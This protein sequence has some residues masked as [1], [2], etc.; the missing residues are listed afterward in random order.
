MCMGKGQ[1]HHHGGHSHGSLDEI[2][3]EVMP[4]GLVKFTTNQFSQANHGS[5]EQ[6][7]KA[8]QSELG[9]AVNINRNKGRVIRTQHQIHVH[10]S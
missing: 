8:I 10:E 7:I 1:H 6:I 5:A 9:G 2:T 3:V 4:G